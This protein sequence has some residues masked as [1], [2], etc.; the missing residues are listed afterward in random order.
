[1]VH[2]KPPEEEVLEIKFRLLASHR[3]F[4]LLEIKPHFS[5]RNSGI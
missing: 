5:L 4:L 2:G 3:M 1:V